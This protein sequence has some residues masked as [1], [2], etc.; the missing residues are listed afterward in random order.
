[1]CCRLRAGEFSGLAAGL[2]ELRWAL[3][4]GCSSVGLCDQEICRSTISVGSRGKTK[5][6]R[7]HLLH[8]GHL[9]RCDRPFAAV[10]CSARSDEP[11][12]RSGSRA[13]TPAGLEF[14]PSRTER[15]RCAH[16]DGVLLDTTE[17]RTACSFGAE[18]PLWRANRHEDPS[19]GPAARGEAASQS[20]RE[21]LLRAVQG[22][23]GSAGN[24]PEGRPQKAPIQL[25]RP[26]APTPALS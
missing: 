13:R 25:R 24:G 20:R 21:G 3:P 10:S 1:M 15:R 18:S 22:R 11:A 16:H 7:A 12:V 8:R 26:P 2:L 4:W 23:R 14:V 6:N 9:V 17:A 5:P 19:P